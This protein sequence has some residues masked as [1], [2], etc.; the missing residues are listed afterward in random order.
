MGVVCFFYDLSERERWTAELDSARARE[1][2]NASELEAL[3]SEAPLGLAMID[4]DLR[5]VRINHALAEMNGFAAEAHVGRRVWDLVPA[6]RA[7][8]EPSLRQV[9]DSGEALRNV[10]VTGETAAQP[11]VV[12][13]WIEQFYPVRDA[14]GQVIGIGVVAEEV[15]EAPTPGKGFTRQRRRAASAFSTNFLPSSVS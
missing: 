7:S 13:E 15:T 8:A 11:G 14:N 12:R 2:R 5:F 1:T 4:A 6:L 10:V 3:Y 9:L